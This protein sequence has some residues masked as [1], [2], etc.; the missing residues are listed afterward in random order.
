MDMSV[1]SEGGVAKAEPHPQ[2]Q[3]KHVLSDNNNETPA[4]VND[5]PMK[6]LKL[7]HEA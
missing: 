4:G 5:Q 6:T 7:Q 3:Q 1:Y 2:I